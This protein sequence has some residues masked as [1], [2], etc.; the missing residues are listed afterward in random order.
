MRT[1]LFKSKLYAVRTWLEFS[2]LDWETLAEC[3]DQATSAKS[4]EAMDAAITAT[5]DLLCPDAIECS[6][7]RIHRAALLL[8]ALNTI[9]DNPTEFAETFNRVKDAFSRLA[10]RRFTEQLEA[11]SNSESAQSALV[12]NND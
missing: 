6:D 5:L 8:M 3:L 10:R 11:W 12:I 2:G 4:D 7:T 9:T 1:I